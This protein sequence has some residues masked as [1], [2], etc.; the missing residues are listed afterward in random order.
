ML[1]LINVVLLLE[2]FAYPKRTTSG[3]TTHGLS[4]CAPLV[5][6]IKKMRNNNESKNKQF[7]SHVNYW[8]LFQLEISKVTH[9]YIINNSALSFNSCV[10]RSFVVLF[11]IKVQLVIIYVTEI[12]ESG[13]KNPNY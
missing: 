4:V 7:I 10:V 13:I 5:F 2:L 3:R 1:L 8:D 6:D 11:V 12:H 9:I